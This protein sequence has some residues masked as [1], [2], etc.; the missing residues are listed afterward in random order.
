MAYYIK[1]LRYELQRQKQAHPPQ[2]QK[3]LEI[4]GLQRLDVPLAEAD[5]PGAVLPLPEILPFS[6]QEDGVPAGAAIAQPA[7]RRWAVV[8]SRAV[9]HPQRRDRLL[10][11]Q[12]SI[13]KVS[14][15]KRHR[16]CAVSVVRLHRLRF[17]GL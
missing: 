14:L 10:L 9:D 13:F 12:L 2:A 1:L 11:G 17:Q 3:A 4:A 7:H 16:A 15:G 6:K 8:L 5:L